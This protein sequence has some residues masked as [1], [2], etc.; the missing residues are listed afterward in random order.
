MRWNRLWRIVTTT[1]ILMGLWWMGTVAAQSADQSAT[2]ETE[3]WRFIDESKPGVT[4]S[5][6]TWLDE[7]PEG[8]PQ[9]AAR[10]TLS[11]TMQGLA[12]HL[13][14]VD[15][16]M[17]R[18]RR[19]A[20]L[21]GLRYCTR[22]V[23]AILPYGIMLQISYDAD[24][25]DGNQSWQGR[26]VYTP[27]NNGAV[28]QGE[29]QC[30]DTLTGN[31]T[32]TGGPLAMLAPTDSPQP[33]ETLL[34]GYPNLGLHPTF[35]RLVLKAGDGWNGFVGDASGLNVVL[36]AEAI[37]LGFGIPQPAVAPSPEPIVVADPADPQNE[38][39]PQEEAEKRDEDDKKAD[40]EKKDKEEKDQEKEERRN[41][42]SQR[43]QIWQDLLV[44]NWNREQMAQW[45]REWEAGEWDHLPIADGINGQ[46]IRKAVEACKDGAWDESGYRNFG[47]CVAAG[48]KELHIANN[49]EDDNKN[50]DKDDNNND[51]NN[52][53]NNN[54]DD[55]DDDDD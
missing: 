53:D 42:R 38:E 40:K 30:W 50:S 55:D 3:A 46:D 6:G 1:G 52:N 33:L 49:G 17:L 51:D 43:E 54:N 19:V 24:V 26:L 29:W 28:V 8:G 10:F 14:P 44:G 15:D 45:Q 18:G 23:D 48:V 31:W 35:G 12:L 37:D 9:I 25:T 11:S 34:A 39:K 47:K 5:T 7:G 41:E 27:A 22:L 32:A 20:A 4:V 16:E 36:D 13:T 2:P 21:D